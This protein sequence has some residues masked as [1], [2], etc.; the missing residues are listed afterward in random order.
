MKDLKNDSKNLSYK[1]LTFIAYCA[2]EVNFAFSYKTMQ[3][4]FDRYYGENYKLSTLRKEFSILKNKGLINFKTRYHKPVPV[5]S[6][7]GRLIL[8]TQLPFKKFDAWDNRWRMVIFDIPET[9][10][11]DRL[12]LC[13][14]LEELGFGHFQKSAYISPFP[15]L[16]TVERFASN[17]GIRQ[18]IQLLEI[19]KIDNEK[20]LVEKV[21]KISEINDYYKKFIEKAKT[22]SKKDFWALKAKKLEQEF[23]V[24]YQNDPHLPEK[25]LPKNWVG[26]KAYKVF[27]QI[28]NSY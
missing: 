12:V 6:D 3:E 21:W 26:D 5:I 10:R 9:Q 4:V 18:Y 2:R 8:K 28:S 23:A 7:K 17:L 24:I 20:R 25:F 22:E 14:K 13:H 16:S 11:A 27:K 19:S 1:I 15:L